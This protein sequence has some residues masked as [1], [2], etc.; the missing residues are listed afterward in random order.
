MK[1]FFAI[2]IILNIAIEI[3]S[4]EINNTISNRYGAGIIFNT[5]ASGV[6]ADYSFY[7]GFGIKYVL[8][9]VY[10]L[11]LNEDEYIIINALPVMYN[12]K[13]DGIFK[14]VVFSGPVHSHHH[15]TTQY[16]G[17]SGSFNDITI[18]AGGGLNINITDNVQA[19]LSVW[20][21]YDYNVYNKNGYKHKGDRFVLILPF[22]DVRILF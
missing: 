21:N 12:F 2:L 11:N 5:E 8:L 3:C 16:H 10:G 7:S 19:G 6:E 9:Y 13:T 20:F 17:K 14:P 22:L 1:Y 18:G 15:W 4:Q